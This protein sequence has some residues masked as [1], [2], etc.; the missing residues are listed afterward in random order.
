VGVWKNSLKDGAGQLQQKIM[1]VLKCSWAQEEG[2][3]QQ[4]IA[5]NSMGLL[6]KQ[7]VQ[8]GQKR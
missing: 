7:D 5:V 8:G 6:E 4:W 3:N 2:I 1:H